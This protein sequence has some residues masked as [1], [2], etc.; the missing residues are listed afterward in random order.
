MV[1]GWSWDEKGKG[2]RFTCVGPLCREV[3]TAF[4]S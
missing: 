1:Y 2:K 4:S 3:I